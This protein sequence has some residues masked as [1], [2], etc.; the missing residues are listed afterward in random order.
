VPSTVFE[1]IKKAVLGAC[2]VGL[3]SSSDI[4]EYCTRNRILG[5][6]INEIQQRFVRFNNVSSA[7]V[8]S[9]AKKMFGGELHFVSVGGESC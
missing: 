6:D 7:D 4:L 2:I 8:N 3:D 9:A 1:T 5:K